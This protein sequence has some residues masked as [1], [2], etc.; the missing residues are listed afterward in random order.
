M[1]K[2]FV[3][4][5]LVALVPFAVGCF[6]GGDDDSVLDYTTV[7]KVVNMPATVVSGGESLRAA[8][9]FKKFAMYLNAHKLTAT[10]AVINSNGVTYDVTFSVALPSTTVSSE[11]VGKEVAAKIVTEVTGAEVVYV[12]F[13][14]TPVSSSDSDTIKVDVDETTLSPTGVTIVSGGAAATSTNLATGTV[15]LTNYKFYVASATYN[16]ADLASSAAVAYAYTSASAVATLTPTFELEFSEAPT[17]LSTAAWELIVS[18][19]DSTGTAL[20]SYTLKTSED[21]DIFSV[22]AHPTDTK[23]A[24]VKVL[25]S[26]TNTA[27]NLENG[28]TYKVQVS[29]NNLK[30]DTKYLDTPKAYYFKVILP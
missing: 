12:S 20:Q 19:V 5:L 15:T 23:K 22:T 10:K 8:V 29:N 28:K 16:G 21:S 30:T 27:K 25:G 9:S 2:L 7:S 17:N 1:K 11:L 26:T 13:T 24:Y 14:Y 6:G 18:S 4:F 3:L